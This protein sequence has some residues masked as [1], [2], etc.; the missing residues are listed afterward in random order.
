MDDRGKVLE[1]AHHRSGNITK[2]DNVVNEPV[3][4]RLSAE[5]RA[6]LQ[7]TSVPGFLDAEAKGYLS[8]GRAA[9]RHL[10]LDSR[11]LIPSGKDTH[12]FTWNGSD[13]NSVLG[14][15][16]ASAGLDCAVMDVGVTVLDTE[17]EVVNSITA[18]IAASPP[19]IDSIAD[20][21][22]NLQSAKFDEMVPDILLRRLWAKGRQGVSDRVMNVVREI[23]QGRR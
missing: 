17:P 11:N 2:F 15:T 19:N 18:Q 21:V 22:E 5:M 10:G 3:H 4:D 7:D 13:V 14:F 12:L 20:F 9:Y 16:F 8:E 6:V 23:V 1:V